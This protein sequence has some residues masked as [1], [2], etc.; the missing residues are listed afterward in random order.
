MINRPDQIKEQKHSEVGILTLRKDGII[1]FQP[2]EGK[3]EHYIEAMKIEFNIMLDWTKGETCG[4]LSDNRNL[5]KFESDVK[6][7][8]QKNVDKFAN[9]FALIVQSGISSFL[10][11]FF[12][13]L[14]RPPI[15]VKTF[16]SPEKALEWLR[17][18]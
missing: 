15:P 5:K 9:R 2:K 14:N 1:T 6:V 11:N 3:T 16:T 17:E 12:I 13:H 4:F 8:A 10:T 7:F 18:G